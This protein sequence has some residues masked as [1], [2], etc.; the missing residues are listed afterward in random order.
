L[1]TIKNKFNNGNR[2]VS[3]AD[4]IVLGGNAAVEKAA[5]AA[6]HKVSVPF[7]VGRVDATQDNT[8]ISTFENLNPQ[9]DGFRNF[10]NSSGW[11]LARRRSSLSTRP[12]S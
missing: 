3:L 5:A 6:G 4:L 12:S 10:R 9:G 8:D 7:T 1:T 2:Q 11:S